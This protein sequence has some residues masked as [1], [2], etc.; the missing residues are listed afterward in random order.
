MSLSLSFNLLTK[1]FELIAA[2]A[3]FSMQYDGVGDVA[4]DVMGSYLLLRVVV[5]DTVLVRSLNT[6]MSIFSL[7]HKCSRSSLMRTWESVLLFP[8]TLPFCH[9]LSSP[10]ACGP[11]RTNCKRT[12]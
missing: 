11:C 2:F 4:S 10:D 5:V 9:T 12:G 3:P 1:L 8:L 7:A 6:F